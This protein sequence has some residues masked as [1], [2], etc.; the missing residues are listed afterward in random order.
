MQAPDGSAV[1]YAYAFNQTTVTDEA[2]NQR[3]YTYNPLGQMTKVEEP[4]PTLLY[5]TPIAT[6][7]KYYGFGPLYRS[8]QSSQQR[9]FV[10]NWLSQM[11]SQTLPESG[12]TTFSYDAAG[13]LTSKTDARSLSVM[14]CYDDVNRTTKKMYTGTCAAPVAGLVTFGYDAN[15]YTGLRTSMSDSVGSVTY[16]FDTMDRLTQESRT[17][18]GVSGTFSTSYGYN[19][20]GDLTQMTYPS[21]RV[22]NFNYATGGGCCN[23]RLASVV[24]QTTGATL[25]NGMTYN[26]AGE[27]LTRT[28]NPGANAIAETFQYNSRLQLTQIAA[29]LAS[30]S[31][32]NFSYD[33]GTSNTNTGR[34]LSRTDAI[35]PEHSQTYAYDSI[36]RL[37][38]VISGDKT[39]SL[40][41]TFDVW[42]NRTAQT[43]QGLATSKVGSQTS[44][45]ANN[46]NTSFTYDAAGN[47]TNDGSHSYTFNAENQI[48]QMDGGAAVYGYDGEGRRMKKTVGSETTYYF[49]GVGGLL[50]EFTT[51][52]TGATQAASTDRTT[53]RTSD[54]LGSAVLIINASGTVIENNRTLPYGEAWLAENTPSTNDKKFTTYQRD[55]ESGLDCAMNRYYA[56]TSARFVSVDQGQAALWAPQTLNRYPYV[57]NDPINNV[58]PDGNCLVFV[59]SGNNMTTVLPCPGPP[60]FWLD[61]FLSSLSSGPMS[62]LATMLAM[63]FMPTEP[64]VE[65]YQQ[66]LERMTLTNVG[67]RHSDPR[68]N[69][70]TNAVRN[71][72]ARVQDYSDCAKHFGGLKGFLDV[73]ASVDF[74]IAFDADPVRTQHQAAYDQGRLGT[75]VAYGIPLTGHILINDNPVGHPGFFGVNIDAQTGTILH[76]MLH[77]YIGGVDPSHRRADYSG[78]LKDC[79]AAD[80]T[81]PRTWRE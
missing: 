47:Q 51:T 75:G 25:A 54:K 10:Y 27:T 42:G 19:I 9:T 78:M 52:N 53:Y 4:N 56:N 69:I 28:L 3:R 21:G 26:A 34:V 17:L 23:S 81:D 14:Y 57:A 8:D 60:P 32:M 70:L 77:K 12:T 73:L 11:I 7:Y 63:G 55:S 30:T 37:S 35:Q 80:A 71:A 61:S 76:E 29:S 31:M 45:Y 5:H 68:N 41:W 15:G 38:N 43:P 58:D 64:A 50:C 67:T 46:R 1:S 72:I 33:Y 59:N 24:D 44:G 20:K 18:T 40:G 6:T 66:R 62:S 65:S 49:Y 13:R 2:G 22:V 79:H 39:W 16:T 74:E 48:T 36:Y